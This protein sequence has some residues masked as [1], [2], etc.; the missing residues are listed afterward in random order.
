MVTNVRWSVRGAVYKRLRRR[1]WGEEGEWERGEQGGLGL[2]IL[3]LLCCHCRAT[4]LLEAQSSKWA[5]LSVI[6]IRHSFVFKTPLFFLFKVLKMSGR[7]EGGQQQLLR[8]K[9]WLGLSAPL[10]R[11]KLRQML[12]LFCLHG[13]CF[14]FFFLFFFLIVSLIFSFHHSFCSFFRGL[15]ERINFNCVLI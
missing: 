2:Q 1:G 3:Y 5:Y 13:F 10:K 4:L 11:M 15:S 8:S 14:L 12:T 6:W 9:F 7:G